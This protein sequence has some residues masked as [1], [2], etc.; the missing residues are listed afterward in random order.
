MGQSDEALV[1][2]A[3][4]G[5]TAAFQGLMTRYSGAVFALVMGH[6]GKRVDSQDVAQEIFLQC[7]RS[8]PN[9]KEPDKFG[10][11]LYGI[12]KR[13]C[14]NTLRRT[15]NQEVYFNELPETAEFCDPNAPEGV[16]DGIDRRLD[17]LDTVQSLPVIY[18]EVILLRYME[19]KS[20]ADMA[21]LL[22]ITESAVNVRLIK[23]RRMLREKM[24]RVDCSERVR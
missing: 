12:G 22:G 24:D 3:L 14:M 13:V 16:A 11:W 15:R 19:D 2:R 10:S 7:Y 18:R 4:D 8:L 6:L 21:I 20:Y 1:R 9:L 23:A 17:V 5:E